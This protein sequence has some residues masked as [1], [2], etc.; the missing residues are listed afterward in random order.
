[1]VH[2]E[3]AAAVLRIIDKETLGKLSDKEL[4][5]F[6]GNSPA[7]RAALAARHPI[8]AAPPAPA[9]G[10]GS[11]TIDQTKPIVSGSEATPFQVK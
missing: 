9:S 11:V 1:M 6:L 5:E 8:L 3:D 7:A 4:V 10:G 2:P